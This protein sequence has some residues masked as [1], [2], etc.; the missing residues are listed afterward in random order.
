[1]DREPVEFLINWHYISRILRSEEHVVDIGA[2]PGKYSMELARGG[3]D[4]TLVDLTPRLVELA[5]G[6][7]EQLGL[8]GKFRGFHTA[9]ATDLRAF[10]DN[11]FDSALLMGPMYHLQEERQ[12]SAA[13]SE[14]HRVAKPGAPVFVAFMT[15]PRFLM[16][17]LAYPLHWKPN[18]E[19]ES[20]KAFAETGIFNHA[21]PGRFTGAYYYNIDDIEPF[22]ASHGF[23]QTQLIGSSSIV[24]GIQAEQ[25]DYWRSFGEER[26]NIMMDLVFREA[27]N[28]YN[29]A[30]S[31]HLLYIGEKM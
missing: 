31:S 29:L 19:P 20:L 23:R 2:G 25:L 14:L 30:V 27:A 22:M 28:P 16:T 24:P 7:A 8:T 18:H 1:M 12:R 26:F 4:V 17:S 15:R 6:K 13:V 5:R 3:C 9:D 10:E 21:D 11:A